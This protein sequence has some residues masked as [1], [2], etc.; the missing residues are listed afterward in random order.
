MAKTLM[1]P[2]RVGLR[3]GRI[4]PNANSGRFSTRGSQL[5]MAAAHCLACGTMAAKAPRENY[6]L[7]LGDRSIVRTGEGRVGRAMPGP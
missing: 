7:V 3:L 2:R 6:E 1:W 4:R 5:A